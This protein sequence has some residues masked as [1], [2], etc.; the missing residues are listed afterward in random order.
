MCSTGRIVRD[1]NFIPNF[2]KIY[3]RLEVIR[4]AISYEGERETSE[5][6]CL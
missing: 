3:E 6:S 4:V 1:R 5:S 2:H